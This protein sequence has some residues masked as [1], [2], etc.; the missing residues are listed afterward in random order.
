MTPPPTDPIRP[1]GPVTGGIYVGRT[2]QPWHVAPRPRPRDDGD[3]SGGRGRHGQHDEP[4]G[5]APSWGTRAE[6]DP[7]AEAGTYD[8]HGRSRHHRD[9]DDEPPHRHVDATA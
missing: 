5:D 1:I 2:E 8:D 9:E 3:E 4:D 6:E 7:A